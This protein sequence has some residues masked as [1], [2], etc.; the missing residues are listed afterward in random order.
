MD[1]DKLSMS[2]GETPACPCLPLQGSLGLSE[3]CH[4]WPPDGLIL[5]AV[6]LVIMVVLP[7]DGLGFA[8]V[9][10]QEG[11]RSEAGLV[12]GHTLL[13]LTSLG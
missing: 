3:V 8:P 5:G 2:P 9:G 7:L 10:V 11:R 12:C 13:R 1:V 4:G 6:S